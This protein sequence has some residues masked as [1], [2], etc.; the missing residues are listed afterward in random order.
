M[1]L[2]LIYQTSQVF[3]EKA[4]Y[5][6]KKIFGFM[7]EILFTA[8]MFFSCNTLK[9]ISMNNQEYKMRPEIV[10]INNNAP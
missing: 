5:N 1:L 10:N 2:Q 4:W 7:K 9:C 6:I 3:N 8:M